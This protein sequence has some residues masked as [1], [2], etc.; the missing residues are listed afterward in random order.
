VGVEVV[1]DQHDPLGV[2]VVDVDQVLDA[3]RPVD[4]G[5]SVADHDVTPASQRLTDQEQVAD[6][7]ALV[8]IV[9]PGWPARRQRAGRGDLGEQ[10]AAGLVQADQGPLG[11]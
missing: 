2:R 11:S 6:P 4:A 7:T 5:A 9:L 3:V 1:L 10:L 8:L